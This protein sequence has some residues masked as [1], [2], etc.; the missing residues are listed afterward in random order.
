[1]CARNNFCEVQIFFVGIQI[2]TCANTLNGHCVRC[3]FTVPPFP[4]TQL[5]TEESELQ[6]MAEDI[7]LELLMQEPGWRAWM[8]TPAPPL[9]NSISGS[10]DGPKAVLLTGCSGFLGR[11]LV[12]SLLQH[13]R[14]GR[15][16]CHMRGR[17]RGEGEGRGREGIE[18]G[19]GGRG[20]RVEGRGEG[21]ED[22]GEGVGRERMGKKFIALRM[23]VPALPTNNR[24]CPFK[25]VGTV[26]GSGCP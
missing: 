14:C 8:Q 11:H 22:Q 1:M 7:D 15:V 13:P 12:L 21:G 25:S 17:T 4:A 6:A 20:L 24:C 23:Y 5:P 9:S 16:Y 19:G 3:W 18:S 2:S 10:G 26:G